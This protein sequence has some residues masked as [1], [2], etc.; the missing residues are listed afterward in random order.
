MPF[1][2]DDPTELRLVGMG[3]PPYSARGLSQSLEPIDA[4]MHLERTIN[5][6]LLDLS[7]EPMQKYKS[8]IS[9]SDQLPPAVDGVWP[10]K[11]VAPRTSQHHH[12]LWP[13]YG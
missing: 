1:T 13:R 3:V 12:H 11:L 7:Y 4:A 9:G 6:E 10:G 8:T 2:K 5:G